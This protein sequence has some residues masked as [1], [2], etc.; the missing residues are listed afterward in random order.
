[1]RNYPGGDDCLQA[2]GDLRHGKGRLSISQVKVGLHWGHEARRHNVFQHVLVEAGLV[3]SLAPRLNQ[4]F[5]NGKTRL[6]CL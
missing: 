5:Q 6:L 3:V 2:R 1:M 4:L